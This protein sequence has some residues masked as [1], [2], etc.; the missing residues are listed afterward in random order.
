MYGLVYAGVHFGKNI[1]V[2][3]HTLWST[4]GCTQTYTVAVSRKGRDMDTMAHSDFKC[5][6]RKCLI[7]TMSHY[8]FTGHSR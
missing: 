4:H 3:M 2:R 6:I 1:G 5:L 7:M 8:I